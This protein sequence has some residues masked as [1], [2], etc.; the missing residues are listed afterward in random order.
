MVSHTYSLDDHFTRGQG[1]LKRSVL[2][3]NMELKIF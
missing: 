1:N 2:N 3:F